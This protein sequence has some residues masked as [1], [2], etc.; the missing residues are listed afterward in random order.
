M[1]SKVGLVNMCHHCI[2]SPRLTRYFECINSVNWEHHLC[3]GG[4]RV[5]G[6]VLERD[7]MI[8]QFSAISLGHGYY[9]PLKILCSL[10]S[11][12]P[13]KTYLRLTCEHCQ[14]SPSKSALKRMD[15]ITIKFDWLD[16]ECPNGW[17]VILNL[18]LLLLYSK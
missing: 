10:C 4:G 2:R 9:L 15:E 1:I 7:A 18:P 17:V 8:I 16:S 5:S 6:D 11:C 12:F 14:N 13:C 3:G